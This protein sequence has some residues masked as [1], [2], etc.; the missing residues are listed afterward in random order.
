MLLQW[1][2]FLELK[3]TKDLELSIQKDKT[4]QK[5]LTHYLKWLTN[6]IN[7]DA[8]LLNGEQF[9]KYNKDA[10]QNKLFNKMHGVWPDML[11]FA[12]KM[13]LYQLF[14]HKFYRMVHT[15]LNIVKKFQKKCWLLYLKLF[16]RITCFLKD[17]F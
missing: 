7:W 6:F 15:P 2:L 4:S 13:V 16:K 11:Q 3:S 12:N 10:H 14:N 8:D 17:V 5:V 1:E 9:L